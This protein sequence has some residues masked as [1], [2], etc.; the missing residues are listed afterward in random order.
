MVSRYKYQKVQGRQ[1][2]RNLFILVFSLI[3]FG[4][5]AQNISFIKEKIFFKIS[6][7][8]FYVSG[9]YY[10]QNKTKD[11]ARQ[12]VYYPIYTSANQPLLDN[13]K[14]IDGDR[15]KELFLTKFDNNY[16]IPIEI[17]PNST[18]EI[19]ITY[20]Q[21]ILDSSA[22]YILSTTQSWSRP[23]EKAVY[24]IEVDENCSLNYISFDPFNIKK[25]KNHIVYSIKQYDFLPV[26]NLILCYKKHCS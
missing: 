5:S 16:I 18:K 8:T 22:V 11:T 25:K 9:K 1:M 3:S 24:I 14:A 2:I 20:K 13:T 10:F 23:L 4:I 12:L 26:L 19:T 15:K 21:K 17:K 6:N 7:D